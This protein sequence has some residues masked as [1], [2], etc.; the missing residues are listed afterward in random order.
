MPGP[1]RHVVLFAVCA[2]LIAYAV[3]SCAS[4]SP[5]L[6][7]CKLDALKVLPDDPDQATVADAKDVIGRLKA[8]HVSAD[9]GAP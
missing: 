2:G 4:L 6:V 8:C 3:V 9:G 1:S 5:S 7:E